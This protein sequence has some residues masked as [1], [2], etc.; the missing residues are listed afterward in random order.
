MK[1]LTIYGSPRKKGSTAQVL[2]T[3]DKKLKEAGEKKIKSKK[4][5]LSASDIGPC[6]SCLKCVKKGYC[7]VS[8]NFKKISRQ[9]NIT[10]YP[11]VMEKIFFHF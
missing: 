7:A 10:F 1:Y 6:R 8:D 11:S 5:V 9:I 2:N 3:I 4:I